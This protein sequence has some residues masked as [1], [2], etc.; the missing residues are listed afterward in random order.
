[1]HLDIPS[2]IV[3]ESRN[4]IIL[5]D[6]CSGVLPP[7]SVTRSVG[8]TSLP[9]FQA[10]VPANQPQVYLG[11]DIGSKD[12]RINVGIYNQGDVTARAHIEV[13]RE[14]DNAVVDSR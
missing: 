2:G 8:K 10:A 3:V 14:C 7:V 9:I 13:R 1:M 11:A 5:T 4:E 6:M 12:A